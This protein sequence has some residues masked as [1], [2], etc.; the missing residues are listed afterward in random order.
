MATIERIATL[1]DPRLDDF[2]R[3]TDHQLRASIEAERGV[4]VAES[5]LV[6]EAALDCGCEPRCFLVGENH[7]DAVAGL[8][9]RAGDAPAYVLPQ[10]EVEKLT[11]YR[12]VRGVLGAFARPRELTVAEAVAGAS[13]VAVVEDLVDVGN[14]GALFRNA[15]ALGADAVILSPGCADPLWR[16]ALRASMGHALRLPWARVAR[17]EWPEGAFGLLR[18]EGFDVIA[19]ALTEGALPLDAPELKASGKRALVFGTEGTGLAPATLAACDRAAII[20]MVRGV[21]SLNVAAAS[22]VAFWELFG[23]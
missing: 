4:F 17:G 9:E 7:L 2:A 13:R 10:A 16:R 19:L 21:D 1:A 6:V 14:V 3:L 18:D 15:A 5:A 12:M 11:G 20:P 22:A 8:L 23:A